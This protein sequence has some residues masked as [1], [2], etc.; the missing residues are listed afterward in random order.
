MFSILRELRRAVAWLPLWLKIF[1]GLIL[2]AEF[3]II[4]QW[5]RLPFNQPPI[6]VAKAAPPEKSESRFDFPKTTPADKSKS[7]AIQ[8]TLA[9]RMARITVLD[10]KVQPNGTILANGQTI[11]LFGIKHFDSTTVCKRSSGERWA[12]GLHAYAT[13]RNAIAQKKVICD[14]QQ[15]LPNGVSAIC[16]MSGTNIAMILV[17]DGLVELDNNVGDADLVNA[18]KFAQSQKIGI[19]NR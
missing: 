14:P 16:Q 17:R 9:K 18:E 8:A 2:A 6:P 12:C 5:E 4:T 7:A 15:I 19:W 10:P 11:Y 13:L 1:I 3:I